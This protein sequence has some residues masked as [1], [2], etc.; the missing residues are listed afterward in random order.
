MSIM[1]SN[2]DKEVG[3]QNK[4][5]EPINVTVGEDQTVLEPGERRTYP[6]GDVVIAIPTGEMIRVKKPRARSA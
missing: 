1:V 6:A 4:G 5:P 2:E 3:L